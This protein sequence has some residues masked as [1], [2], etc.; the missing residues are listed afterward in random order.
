MKPKQF[1][2][3]LIAC[4]GALAL[5]LSAASALTVT[6]NGPT[7]TPSTSAAQY[8]QYR[9]VPWHFSI[10]IR[11]NL[12]IETSDAKA[13]TT[14]QF[15]DPQG[16]ELSQVSAW[17]YADLDVALG[18]EGSASTASVHSQ[19]VGGDYCATQS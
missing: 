4:A 1:G 11:S 6:S 17:P 2:L 13:G 3:A 5:T 7:A 12:P 19:N 16:N 8:S 9:N 14:V 18:E 10:Q 15:M